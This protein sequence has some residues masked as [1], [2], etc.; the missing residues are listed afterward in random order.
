MFK[1]F[2]L[3]LAIVFVVSSIGFAEE[4]ETVMDDA[5]FY[6]VEA[7]STARHIEQIKWAYNQGYTWGTLGN[8]GCF[9]P[10]PNPEPNFVLPIIKTAWETGYIQSIIDIQRGEWGW[11]DPEDNE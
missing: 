1:R 6:A 2:F 3:A 8:Y 4:P 7:P 9:L 11:T 10:S 5:V